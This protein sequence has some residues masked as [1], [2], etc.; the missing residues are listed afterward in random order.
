MLGFDSHSGAR[1]NMHVRVPGK[2]IKWHGAD[3]RAVRPPVSTNYAIGFSEPWPLG[4][5]MEVQV[6]FGTSLNALP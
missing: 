3:G 1:R 2:A 6:P 5:F 4:V